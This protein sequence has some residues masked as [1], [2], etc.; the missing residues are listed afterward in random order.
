VARQEGERVDLV[1]LAD[2]VRLVGRCSAI[3]ARSPPVAQR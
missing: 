3:A 2:K 1:W